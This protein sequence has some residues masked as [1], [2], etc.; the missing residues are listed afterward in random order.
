MVSSIGR[1]PTLI[2]RK[3]SRR[4]GSISLEPVHSFW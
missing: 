3:G 1:L 4:N 2:I